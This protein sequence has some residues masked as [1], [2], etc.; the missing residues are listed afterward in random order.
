MWVSHSERPLMI[1][2]IQHALAVE[3]GSTD[4]DPENIRPQDT[5]LRSCLGLVVLNE[6]TSTVQLLHYTLQEYLSGPGILPDVHKTL[7]Q[8]CLT[9]LNYEQ[10]KRLPANKLPNLRNMPF[11][12]YSSLYWGSHAKEELSDSAKSLALQ[13]LSRYNNHISSTLLFNHTERHNSSSFTHCQLTGLHCASYFGIVEVVAALIEVEGCNIDQRDCMGYT[14]LM[15]AAW[16]GNE[17]VVGLLLMRG[18]VSTD[19]SA[20]DGWVVPWQTPYWDERLVGDPLDPRGANLYDGGRTALSL[21]SSSG[22]E[23]MVRLLLTRDD[24]NPNKPDN[25]GRT[26]L[27]WASY[28]GNEGVLRLLLARGDINPDRSDSYGRTALWWASYFGNEGVL[29]LLLVRNDVNPDKSDNYGRTAL[30]WAVLGNE[31]VVRLLLARDDVNPN[32]SA[33]DGTIPLLWATTGRNREIAVLLLPRTRIGFPLFMSLIP[34]AALSVC[35]LLV[36]TPLSIG[37]Y[38]M[39]NLSSLAF[40][41]IAPIP[42]YPP[43]ASLN[44]HWVTASLLQPPLVLVANL[45]LLMIWGFGWGVGLVPLDMFW[46]ATYFMPFIHIALCLRNFFVWWRLTKNTPESMV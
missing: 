34:G 17:E 28:F 25:N 2:E 46:L 3:M 35:L 4:L 14:P 26:A 7:A 19:R 44:W 33:N 1:R 15:W 40:F 31:R 24:V 36:T 42:K 30:W 29:N 38:M 23:G 6:E 8:T 5:V 27:W 12:E 13:L 41:L 21:A 20:R 45:G 37:Q 11:L 22:R 10:V 39:V 9:Y 32:K 18:D 43:C 16:R